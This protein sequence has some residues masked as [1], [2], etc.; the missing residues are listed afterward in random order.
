VRAR[1]AAEVAFVMGGLGVAQSGVCY[2]SAE[3]V[4]SVLMVVAARKM[5]RHVEVHFDSGAAVVVVLEEAD[6]DQDPVARLG[7]QDRV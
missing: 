1:V 3:L 2:T 7:I 4:G 5:V 6:A